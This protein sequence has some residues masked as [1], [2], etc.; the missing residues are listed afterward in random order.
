MTTTTMTNSSEQH[1][2][3]SDMKQ[4]QRRKNLALMAVLVGWI[5][6]LYLVAILR[7]SGEG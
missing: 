7:M 1:D 2:Q 4:R 3:R 5:V 6:V